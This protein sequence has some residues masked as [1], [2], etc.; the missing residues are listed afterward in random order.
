MARDDG[1]GA[2][3]RLRGSLVASPIG[4]EMVVLDLDTGLYHSLNPVGALLYRHLCEGATC[5]E[6][7]AAVL[8]HFKVD[9]TRAAADIDAFLADE[10]RIGLVEAA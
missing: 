6:L 3:Y 1:H 7:V 8:E 10:V 2:R 5:D 4:D 9:R